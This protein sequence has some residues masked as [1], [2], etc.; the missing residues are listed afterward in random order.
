M[1][2]LPTTVILLVLVSVAAIDRVHAV[3]SRDDPV[4]MGTSAVI[5]D[6]IWNKGNSY[7]WEVTV[8][9]IFP[10]ATIGMVY[11]KPT[12]GFVR[13][14]GTE[15]FVAK[16]RAKYIGPKSSHF[17]SDDL[18]IVGSASVGYSPINHI[19]AESMIPEHIPYNEVFTGGA[20]TGIV[21]WM[22][23]PAHADHLVMYDST[24]DFNKRTYMALFRS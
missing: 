16:I 6:D 20:V 15:Y 13:D 19:Q 23:Q 3:G 9:D 5:S 4:P 14:P 10:N 7:N 11:G 21:V 22:I 12:E 18:S 2:I 8:L 24:I 1:K 17:D